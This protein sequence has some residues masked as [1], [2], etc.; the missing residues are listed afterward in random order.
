MDMPVLE[1]LVNI[2]SS[3]SELFGSI[4][5][6]PGPEG[7]PVPEVASVF[8]GGAI[9]GF[10]PG[11][12]FGLFSGFVGNRLIK[13]FH[14]K[15]NWAHLG[16]AGLLSLTAAAL[17]TVDM[18]ILTDWNYSLSNEKLAMAAGMFTGGYAGVYSAYRTLANLSKKYGRKSEKDLEN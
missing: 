12:S 16:Y 11:F 4:V 14:K 18:G 1:S 2:G 9:M 13:D 15:S 10:L 8:G 6:D 17:V 7:N 5:L 3:A